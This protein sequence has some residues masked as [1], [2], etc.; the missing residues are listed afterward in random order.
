M[1]EPTL[2]ARYL[3]ILQWGRTYNGSV[4][5]NDLVAAVIVTIMHPQ[6]SATGRLPRSSG[7]MPILPLLAVRCS[8]RAGRWRRVRSRSVTD[9]RI[10]CGR[11][12]CA[13]HG[14]YVEAAITLAALSGILWLCWAFWLG[15]LANL[16]RIR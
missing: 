12:R 7:Y 3:P 14:E 1:A 5:T 15:F 10:C 8:G 2:L 4:L 9:D 6:A 16:P 13:G 11:C